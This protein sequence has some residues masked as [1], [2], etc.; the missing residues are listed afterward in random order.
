MHKQ[1]WYL[2]KDY[3]VSKG[4]REHQLKGEVQYS[5]SPCT[6]RFRSSDFEIASMVYFYKASYFNE[7]VNRT[8][9]SPLVSVP[10]V[11]IQL[12]ERAYEYGLIL[13]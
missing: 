12:P 11:Y 13:L 10:W 1:Y 9:P 2:A 8:E 4:T 7:E 5:W 3:R 6:N